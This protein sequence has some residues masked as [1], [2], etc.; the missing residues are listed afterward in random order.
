LG[1]Q[2][3]YNQRFLEQHGVG[4][5]LTEEALAERIESLIANRSELARIRDRAWALGRRDGA[6]RVAELVLALARSHA[7]D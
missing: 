1:G 7:I 2:E 6:A 5:L 4:A 3:G